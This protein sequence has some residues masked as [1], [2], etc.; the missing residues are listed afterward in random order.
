MP[1]GIYQVQHQLTCKVCHKT[2]FSQKER[3]IY[4]SGLCRNI[5]WRKDNKDRDYQTKE[6]WK[7]NN[8]ERH[9]KNQYN[10][11]KNRLNSDLEYKLKQRVRSRLGRIKF[12]NS[13]RTIEWLGCSISKLK[14]HLESKFQ[15]GM[16][17][18]NYGLKGW[19]IDHIK[20]LSSF[21]LTDFEELKVACCYTNLQPLWAKD[22]LVK[23]NKYEEIK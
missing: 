13:V 6:K 12:N 3:S 8:P 4:C 19:H 21:D 22:N 18:E 7:I 15:P 1:K 14:T 11:K 17:W 20:P 23:S 5:Q 9:Q 10:Y 2:Y 16:T